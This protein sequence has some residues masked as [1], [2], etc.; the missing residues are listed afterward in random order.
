MFSNLVRMMINGLN[1]LSDAIVRIYESFE[2]A[3]ITITSYSYGRTTSYAAA[4]TMYA[5]APEVPMLARGAVIPSNAPFLAVLG[6]QK[7]G[8]N[9]EAP[10]ATIQE[11]VALVMDDV[12]QSNLA[13]FEAVVSV[14]QEIL[15]TL[16][17]IEIGDQV[18]AEA[19]Q[20]YQAKMAVVRGG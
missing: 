12:V 3:A 14:L 7:H 13:G 4:S 15:E 17:G 2:D 20:R 6:D 18:I 10:L 19:V 11:A 5:A 1:S 8:T 9:V 16:L